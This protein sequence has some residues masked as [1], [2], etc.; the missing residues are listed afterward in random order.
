MNIYASTHAVAGLCRPSLG[1]SEMKRIFDIFF[2]ALALLFLGIPMIILVLLIQIKL[3]SPVLYRQVRPGLRGQ[4]FTIVK[5]RSMTDNRGDDGCLLPDA[6]RLS[7]FGRWLRAT[8]IDELPELWNVLKGD[9]SLVGPRP[10][11]M[12]YL[13][14][15]SAE[16]AR[17]HEVRPGVTGWAQV[18][19]RNAISWEDKFQLDVWYVNN[20]TLWLDLKILF[21]T[22]KKVIIRDGISAAGEATMPAFEGSKKH[23]K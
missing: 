19:G 20:H 21:L 16:Q 10:L 18:N 4:P 8:S 12:Q 7:P 13:P 11:L 1:F 9:M 23:L 22:I 6:Q 14:L 17:R 2:S 5:F 3:G 15:Y